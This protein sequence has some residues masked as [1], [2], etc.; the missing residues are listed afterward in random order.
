MAA[1]LLATLALELGDLR[2]DTACAVSFTGAVE[3]MTTGRDSPT[4]R[5]ST[6][7]STSTRVAAVQSCPGVD[8]AGGAPAAGVHRPAVDDVADPAHQRPPGSTHNRSYSRWAAAMPV[9]SA[10]S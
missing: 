10:W 9:I 8:Q 1:C 5:S 7:R 2:L 3:A 6:D 4:R